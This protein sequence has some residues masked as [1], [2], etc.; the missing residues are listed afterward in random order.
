MTLPLVSQ[1]YFARRE[2]MRCLEGL[3]EDDGRRRLEPMNSISWIVGH[4]ASQEQFLWL[5]AAQDRVI[6]PDLYKLVGFGRPATTPP[7]AEMW[8]V[9]HEITAAADD[10]LDGL[11]AEMQDEHLVWRGRTLEESIGTSLLRNI[12]H[13]WFH[14]GEAHA[15]RQMLGHPD[16]PQFVGDLSGVSY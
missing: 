8:A 14:I 11:T 9:W 1:L 2:F 6:T 4:L 16:L 5:M 3:S 12:N 15:V 13:Y 7:L 10:Y